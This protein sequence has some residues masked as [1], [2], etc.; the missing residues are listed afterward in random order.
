MGRGSGKKKSN[1][2]IIGLDGEGS[3][4]KPHR[5][6]LLAASDFSGDYQK[7]IESE[8]LS[9][10]ECLDFLCK[11]GQDNIEGYSFSFNYDL[12]MI[13]KDLP[14][15]LLYHLFRPELRKSKKGPP[16]AI[17]W[18]DFRINYYG[19]RFAVIRIKRNG[20]KVQEKPIVIW[21][22]FKFFQCSFVKALEDWKICPE[23]TLEY[24]S[25]M[26][27]KRS[28]FDKE[29]K[30]NIK[31][32]C[33]SECQY[34]AKLVTKLKNAHVKAGLNL[35]SYYGAGSTA[36]A[37]LDT[38]GIKKLVKEEIEY[39]SK[40]EK[41]FGYSMRDAVL[42]AFFGGRFENSIVGVINTDVYNYDISSAYPYQISQLP[43]LKHGVWKLT[44]N[45][46]DLDSVNAALIN[47]K[48]PVKQVSHDDYWGPLPFR[49]KDGS[50][51]Y[52]VSGGTGWTYKQEFIQAE[53]FGVKFLS[54][55]IL[56][57]TCKCRPFEKFPI[58]Y[59]ERCRIGKDGPGIVIK[60]GTNAGYGKLAQSVG[61]P[62]YNSWLWASMITSG[63]RAQ[64]LEA[65][66]CHK[67]ISNLLMIATDGI[68]S[69]EKLNLP[70]P[71]DTGTN[72]TG[73]PLGGWEEKIVKGGMFAA[74]PGINFPLTQKEQDVKVVRGR[75]FGRKIIIS[76]LSN[77]QE[78]WTNY[79][80]NQKVTFPSVSRFCGAKNHVSRGLKLFDEFC[81]DG[82]LYYYKR[83]KDY[84]EWIEKSMYM[85]FNPLPKRA[86]I[87]NDNRLIP[88]YLSSDVI[89]S[90]YDKL[91]A[92][93][94][95]ED[96]FESIGEEQPL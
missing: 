31:G 2:L 3:G 8:S 84:G 20:V 56:L 88:H 33:L 22:V 18:N 70:L 96:E 17:L 34:L 78:H 28:D 67:N 91:T 65:A 54:A 1:K 87:R 37:L 86:G 5:Y 9:T 38:I 85:S 59:I 10:F 60:L 71:I 89:S 61:K 90:P 45:R 77:I 75:G 95:K 7:T 81:Q 44:Y 43:C 73:K 83:S 63:C 58:Y 55:W 49:T 24:I 14:N 39:S 15:S 57:Q 40:K 66:L 64:I 21:D 36:A 27:D 41:N 92:E 19:T 32:Y 94:N 68:Y 53:K 74:K 30:I 48:N 52:P 62:Q 47:W 79:G 4:R 93:E 23:K 26:K 16:K 80:I 76:N 69:R 46:K 25:S 50:I 6:I 13:L 35:K 12:T 51:I 29:E 42:T 82:E 72:E 11:L